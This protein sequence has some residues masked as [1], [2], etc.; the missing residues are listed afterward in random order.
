MRGNHSKLLKRVISPVVSASMV[1]SFMIAP[2]IANADETPGVPEWAIDDGQ[3]AS[4]LSIQAEVPSKYDLR[5][6]GLVTPVKLQNPWGSCWAFGGTAAV[7]SSILSAY[8][9]TYEKSKLDISEKH[10]AYFALHPISA[11]VDPKQA[12]EGLVTINPSGNAAYDSGGLPIYVTSLFSQGVGPVSEE[13]FPYRGK[14]AILTL[15]YIN[16][17]PQEAAYAQ[18]VKELGSAEAAEQY[19]QAQMAASGKTRE[20]V[21]NAVA[22]ILRENASNTPTYSDQDDWSI[23]EK[24]E[25]GSS[26]RLISGGLVLKDGNVL[27]NYFNDSAKEELNEECI[28]AMKQELLNG[29]GVSIMYYADQG[30]YMRYA[31]ADNDKGQGY[32]EYCYDAL[33][34]DHSVCVVGYDAGYSKENFRHDVYKLIDPSKG[35]V[36]S[37]FVKEGDNY[38]V[39][40][41]A[42]KKTIPPCDGAWIVKN[43]WGSET[44]GNLVDDLGNAV[45]KG[46]F[47][48]KDE[49]GKATGYFY[50]SFCDRSIT[51]V[52]TMDFT[53]NLTSDGFYT[54]QHDYMPAVA[55]FYETSTGNEVMSSA[56]VFTTDDAMELKSVS[57]RTPEANMRVT[58]ALY[59]LNDN[60]KDP[61]DGKLL[62]R[63]S[64][65][66]QYGGFHRLDL[67]QKVTFRKGQRFSVVSTASI[68]EKGGQRAYGVSA[69][70]GISKET[71]TQNNMKAYNVATINEGESFLYSDGKWQDWKNYVDDLTLETGGKTSKYTDLYPID[72]FSIKAYAVPVSDADADKPMHRLYNPNSGE[73]FYTASDSERDMLVD[74]GWTNEGEGWTAPASSETPVYRLYNAN[75]GEHHYTMDANERDALIAAGWNAEGIG[76]YSD[77]GKGVPLYREYNPNAFANN[78]NY[79]AD[80]NE[81]KALISIGWRDEGYAWY[82]LKGA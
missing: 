12:G 31:C 30:K 6:D 62:Y 39:D 36:E 53:A 74:L 19:I 73:H 77:D 10:L 79:T 40:E 3:S 20:E 1:F 15:D 23:P 13:A 65:N 71:A 58:F 80:E 63:T 26:N 7:E 78:H 4:A 24:N 28:T 64:E 60:A 67:D 46:T 27:P 17:H 21:L 45:N 42:T 72:N 76:W 55:G 8:G 18:L 16:A 47:G 59:L 52:E 44:D 11:D 68:V 34:L 61:T 5:D 2:A 56:N 81:H 25:D 70:R 35:Y 50:L 75:G 66:F 14:D 32:A 29:R 43:S 38:V 9:S 48:I 22:N 49:N 54:I 69:C 51:S 82:G 37:N 57:T 33:P 41:D